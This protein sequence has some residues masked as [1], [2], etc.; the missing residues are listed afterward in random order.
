MQV[1]EIVFAS[2]NILHSLFFVNSTSSSIHEITSFANKNLTLKEEQTYLAIDLH[3][4]SFLIYEHQHFV[5]K[6][7]F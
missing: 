3:K 6:N 2:A 7:T 4:S 1:N 5:K